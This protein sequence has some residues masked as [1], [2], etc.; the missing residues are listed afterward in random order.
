MVIYI[1]VSYR[2][3]DSGY[4]L[5]QTV[6]TMLYWSMVEACLGLITSCLPVLS[7]LLRK[8]RT[9]KLLHE[10]IRKLATLGGITHRNRSFSIDHT[11]RHETLRI[12]WMRLSLEEQG[13]AE[14][15]RN[16]LDWLI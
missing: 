6:T 14:Q 1:I 7:A 5:D 12:N 15:P 2:T 3:F 11:K 8:F 9:P 4:D 13:V 16:M 10:P